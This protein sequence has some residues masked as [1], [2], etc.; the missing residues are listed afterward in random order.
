VRLTSIAAHNDKRQTGPPMDHIKMLIEEA[1][2]NHAYPIKQKLKD[3][4]MMRSFMKCISWH[5]YFYF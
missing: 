5:A 2:P 4:G 3:C 1:C